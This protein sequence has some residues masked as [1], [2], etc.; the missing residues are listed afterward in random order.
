MNADAIGR[1]E[2]H[3]RD[4]MESRRDPKGP[5]IRTLTD[6]TCYI[7][8]ESRTADGGVVVTETDITERRRAEEARERLSQAVENVRVGIALFDGDDRLVFCNSRYR[9]LMDVMADV[10][11]PGVSFEEM[12]RAIVARAP[13]KDAHGRE[14]EYIRERMARHRNPT[15]PVDLRREDKWL[16]ANEIRMP[17]GSIFVIITDITERKQAEEALGK[18]GERLSGA[19]ESLQE[20]FALF[21]ATDRLVA[22]NDKYRRVNPAAQEILEKGGTFEDLIRANMKRGV[23]VE[24]IGREEAFLAERLERHRNPGEPIIRRMTDGRWFML[25]EART[26]EGGIALSFIDITDLKRAEEASRES[27]QRFKD[28]AEVASDWFWEMDADLRFSYFS[29]RNFEITGYTSAEVIGKTRQ[30]MAGDDTDDARWRQHFADLE[31]H[32]P[33]QDFRYPLATPDGGTLYISVSGKPIFGADGSFKGYRGTGADITERV[34]AEKALKDSEERFRNLVEGSIQGIIIHREH[35]AVFANKAYAEIFGYDDPLEI[36]ELDSVLQ[37]FAPHEQERI[38]RY[39]EAR[40][41]GEDAPT[42]YE[43]QGVRRDGSMLWLENRVRVVNWRGERAI[44]TTIIDITVRKR[45]E[46]LEKSRAMVLEKLAVGAPLDEVLSF[47]AMTVEAIRRE[48]VC[49]V[50]IVDKDAKRLRHGAAP[51][52]PNFYNKAVDGIK[53]APGVGCCGS[54]AATGKTVIVREIA[55]HPD[56]GPFRKIAKKAG[57]QACWSQPIFSTA[58]D[59]L[60]T[61][62]MYYREP[63]EP[64]DADLEI[65]NSAANLAGIAIERKNAEEALRESESRFRD[66]AESAGDWIWEMGPD[67]RFT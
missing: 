20:G 14:E 56:W 57:L 36:L 53:I 12:V 40:N 62:A 23:L 49:S 10:V 41:R 13:V 55:T 4:R 35:K 21:D 44:Q 1:E 67:L 63:R 46:I 31:A 15:G 51:S 11:E 26:P 34:E 50:L 16:Q 59:V 45:A 30:D 65:I 25:S 37:L 60:G 38:I 47:L 32:R 22:I 29:G 48:M 64:D 5:I 58:G 42:T 27:H 17:D 61:F 52:L 8:K 2:D 39:R 7:I 9:E 6:G 28:Y 19:I 43:V 3:I 33:F 24:A 18:S 54:A 66:V